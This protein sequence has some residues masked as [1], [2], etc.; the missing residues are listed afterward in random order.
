MEGVSKGQHI[1]DGNSPISGDF[2]IPRWEV[3]DDHEQK[4]SVASMFFH[5]IFFKFVFISFYVNGCVACAP[6]CVWYP[7][8]AS[9]PLELELQPVVSCHKGAGN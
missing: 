4:G 8:G 7:R 6:V 3:S 2:W 9:D 5:K 1:E